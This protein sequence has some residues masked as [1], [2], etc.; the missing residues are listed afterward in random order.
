LPARALA[1]VGC[2]TVR[3]NGRWPVGS[4]VWESGFQ[5]G[6]ASSAKRKLGSASGKV[7]NYIYKV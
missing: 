2:Q 1:V 3:S 5:L 6:S 7:R 4:G